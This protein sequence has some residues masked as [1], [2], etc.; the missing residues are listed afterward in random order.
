[1]NRN[2]CK[3]CG[4]FLTIQDASDLY[5]DLCVSCEDKRKAKYTRILAVVVFAAWSISVV[6][7]TLWLRS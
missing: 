2:R 1:M 7:V 5:P 3:A 6:L 4:R